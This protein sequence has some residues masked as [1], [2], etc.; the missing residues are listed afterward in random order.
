MSFWLTTVSNRTGYCGDDGANN[1][2]L[3]IFR[4]EIWL[5]KNS[6]KYLKINHIYKM[7]YKN[8]NYK[9]NQSY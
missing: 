7:Y 4:A 9:D 3:A 5:L 6:L 1:I 8:V 2:F